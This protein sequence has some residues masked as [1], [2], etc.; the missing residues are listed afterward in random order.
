MYLLFNKMELLFKSL[1]DV[2]SLSVLQIHT[3]KLAF[4]HQN[5][6][7]YYPVCN[8]QVNTVADSVGFI[9]TLERTHHDI[10]CDCYYVVLIVRTCLFRGIFK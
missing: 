4:S 6:F 9:V 2:N 3:C 5:A 7:L 8:A 10:I 1:L